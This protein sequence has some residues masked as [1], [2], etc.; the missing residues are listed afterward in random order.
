MTTKEAIKNLRHYR[1]LFDTSTINVSNITAFVS[2]V[3]EIFG[4]G[5]L[6]VSIWAKMFLSDDS[7]SMIRYID[8]L[9]E[10][11]ETIGIKKKHSNFLGIFDNGTLITILTFLIGGCFGLGVLLTNIYNKNERDELSRENKELTQTIKEKEADLSLLKYP[12]ENKT[13][14]KGK[15]EDSKPKPK[16]Y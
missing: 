6:E 16:V 2:L 8:G 11:L 15:T 12:L 5:S 9:I 14:T 7:K 4:E 3:R 13:K 1:N 10:I